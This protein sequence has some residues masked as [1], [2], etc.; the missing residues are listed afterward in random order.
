MRFSEQI[1][2]AV[3]ENAD[4][5]NDRDDDEDE[6]RGSV[7]RE[8]GEVAE[9]FRLVFERRHRRGLEALEI[10]ERQ[11]EVMFLSPGDGGRNRIIGDFRKR[12]DRGANEMTGGE[13]DRD[14]DE[15]EDREGHP[16]VGNVAAE[17]GQNEIREEQ[18]E[19]RNAELE[20]ADENQRDREHEKRPTSLFRH[21][22]QSGCGTFVRP[23]STG[24]GEAKF[25]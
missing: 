3:E 17:L 6:R 11:I 2:P 14:P 8:I 23:V 19:E 7:P 16:F 1:E 21:R 25:Q 15:D 10:F 18:G 12:I 4:G 9:I 20:K 22:V 24:L 5:A 13:P